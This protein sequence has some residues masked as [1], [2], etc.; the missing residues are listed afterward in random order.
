MKSPLSIPTLILLYL[1]FMVGIA[2]GVASGYLHDSGQ[3]HLALY[4]G[5][6]VSLVTSTI[7]IRQERVRAFLAS[8]PVLWFLFL[9]N[10]AVAVG[11]YFAI[12]GVKGMAI[13]AGM[14]LVSLGAGSGLLRKPRAA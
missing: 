13:A 9:F 6:G 12:G 2:A 8:R 14:G 10:G 1:L 7:L 3:K 5:I 11:C 4:S